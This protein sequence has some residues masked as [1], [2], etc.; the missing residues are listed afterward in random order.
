MPAPT[1]ATD[2]LRESEARWEESRGR[3]AGHPDPRVRDAF[4]RFEDAHRY[5][6]APAAGPREA[7]ILEDALRHLLA[8]I[9]DSPLA[10]S[11][12]DATLADNSAA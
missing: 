7:G 11:C 12:P 6:S 8:T 3:L 2:A 4:R 10:R 1:P 5:A 9:P